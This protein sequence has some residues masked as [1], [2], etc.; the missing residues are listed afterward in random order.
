MP[1]HSIP[2]ALCA[3]ARPVPV[4]PG[5]AVRE[6]LPPDRPAQTSGTVQTSADAASAVTV[7][8]PSPSL[9]IIVSICIAEY[10][11]FRLSHLAYQRYYWDREDQ[12][13]TPQGYC[14]KPW[15]RRLRHDEN[16]M[17]VALTNVTAAL[18]A[19]VL[20]FFALIADTPGAIR[21][22]A[23]VIGVM[24]GVSIALNQAGHS[25]S[26]RG[27]YLFALCATVFGLSTVL[28]HDSGAPMLY[29]VV[30]LAAYVLFDT[31]HRSLSHWLTA[32]V[33]CLTLADILFQLRPPDAWLNGWNPGN[34]LRWI[35]VPIAVLSSGVLIHLLIRQVE[36]SQRELMRNREKLEAIITT[37]NDIVFEV[38][39]DLGL[40]NIWT[41][42]DS[43]L[44]YPRSLYE[45]MHPRDL[46][47]ESLYDLFRQHAYKAESTGEHV[48]FGYTS[49]TNG[50]YYEVDI[51]PLR[52][53]SGSRRYSVALRDRSHERARAQ[54]MR[55]ND[56]IIRKSWTAVLFA[57]ASGIIT[58]ANDAAHQLYAVEDN[59]TLTGTELARWLGPED[60]RKALD[61]LRVSGTYQ[62]E[63]E[64]T[65][66]NGSVF[67]AWVSASSIR[68]EDSGLLGHAFFLR[69]NTQEKM[70]RTRVVVS[71]RRFRSMT[72][73]TPGVVYEVQCTRDL[74]N[75]WFSFVSSQ[76]TRILGVDPQELVEDKSLL[77]RRMHPEDR[78]NVIHE[79]RRVAEAN[80][81]WR[82]EFRLRV[83]DEERWIRGNSTPINWD[84]DTLVYQGLLMDI[85]GEKRYRAML[86]EKK[87]QAEAIS[88]IKSEFLSTMSHEIRTPLNAIIGLS[89]LLLEENP[90][91]DQ[92]ENLNTL[93]F[94]AQNLLSLINDILDYSRIEAGR[95]ELERIPFDLRTLVDSL[96]KAHLPIA[97]EKGLRLRARIPD[98]LATRRLG[99]PT[100][101]TQ[102]LNNLL[103]NAI[104]FTQEGSVELRIREDEGMT[105][106]FSVTDTGCGIPADK[107]ARIFERFTQADE[108]ITRAFG[109]TGLGLAI[110]RGLVDLFG[111]HLTLESEEDVGSTFAFE[112]NLPEAG[113]ADQTGTEPA[114]TNQH[115]L[116]GQSILLVDD[117]QVNLLVARKL[118]TRWGAEVHTAA[119]GM[120]AIEACRQ[121]RFDII[122]MDLQMPLMD[123]FEATTELHEKKLVDGAY[124]IAL[125]AATTEDVRE[126]ALKAGMDDVL[127]KPINPREL[128]ARLHPLVS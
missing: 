88:R 78:E 80:S 9:P 76:A 98:T 99:D 16:A 86:L 77:L 28:G 44:P 33:V 82:Q 35:I 62:A 19:A 63:L 101:L 112:V 109:G 18:G 124:I 36:T 108:S 51:I 103:S 26:G 105:I 54:R 96:V 65:R 17:R 72:E 22:Q 116:D 59:D 57:D 29:P 41:S 125:T 73:H 67:S 107:Q 117:N 56:E 122:L 40:L 110:T 53:A 121:R 15:F 75:W 84:G 104:K 55:I 27:L 93:A 4:S 21:V 95:I 120:D 6:S 39:E 128:A 123:G 45:S 83:G 11:G 66:A 43:K 92:V 34:N 10:R 81:P 7:Y 52:S 113:D 114:L 1:G 46:L 3:Q 30:I 89:H 87:S 8:R 38:D 32:L 5:C 13:P 61:D 127:A 90:R 97:R 50:H 31:R 37:M 94:S 85:T 58:Y 118:L 2:D 71:E 60:T 70:D 69:D 102:I 126:R 25:R 49:P 111:G 42:D 47:P 106:H 14:V 79:L 91:E 74:S 23:G 24:F 48:Q 115:L 20:I 100:R 12:H 68:D 119:N 64:Q